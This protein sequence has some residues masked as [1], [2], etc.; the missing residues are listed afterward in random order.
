MYK[1]EMDPTRTVGATDAGAFSIH[2]EQC[3]VVIL[4]DTDVL[5][6]LKIIQLISQLKV[7][8][9]ICKI[10]LQQ[11]QIVNPTDTF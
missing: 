3:I 4:F 2:S 8:D 10:S 1:Y 6:L 5:Q 9:G 7:S 11:D